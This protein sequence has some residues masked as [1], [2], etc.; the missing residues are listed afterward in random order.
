MGL[1]ER[2]ETR[3]RRDGFV[4]PRPS[5]DEDA[6][7]AEIEYG[8]DDPLDERRGVV[9]ARHHHATKGHA[10]RRSR[11]CVRLR[12]SRAPRTNTRRALRRIRRAR[13]LPWPR[14]RGEKAFQHVVVA[15]AS[16]ASVPVPG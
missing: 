8:R 7:E 4:R 2:R 9:G 3:L 15:R 13:T 1:D 11:L 12:C 14:R 5:G 16:S 6:A 10:D